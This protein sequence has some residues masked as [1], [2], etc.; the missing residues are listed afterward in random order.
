MVINVKSERCLLEYIN[1]LLLL[2]EVLVINIV[3]MGACL[4]TESPLFNEAL[5]FNITVKECLSMYSKSPT[6]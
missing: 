1:N 5:V 6:Q 4:H 3:I 2:S